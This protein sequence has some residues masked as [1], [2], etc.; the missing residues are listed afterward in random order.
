MGTLDLAQISQ[1]QAE[2]AELE[3]LEAPPLTSEELQHFWYRGNKRRPLP[4]NRADNA[5][6]TLVN[7]ER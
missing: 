5:K 4:P 2:L 7:G 6:L 1:I 3:T